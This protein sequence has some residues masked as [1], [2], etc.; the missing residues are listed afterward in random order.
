[1]AAI[2]LLF[3]MIAATA[4]TTVPAIQAAIIM[5]TS[6]PNVSSAIETATRANSRLFTLFVLA[7]LAFGLVTA[8]LT[9]RVRQS[10]TDLQ[11]AIRN[12]AYA[13]IEEA[14]AEGEK[15]YQAAKKLENDNLILRGDLNGAMGQVA[16][17][18]REAAAQ[19]ERAAMAEHAL[20]ELQE[21]MAYRGVSDDQ[22]QTLKTELQSLK[23]E[24]I[25][26]Y[27][28]DIKPEINGYARRI[29]GVLNEAEL[30]ATF[31]SALL[32]TSHIGFLFISGE[33][34]LNAAGVIYT[35]FV[36]ADLA[37]GRMQLQKISDANVLQLIVGPKE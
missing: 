22:V 31:Q 15:A 6:Q 20:L 23:G 3:D 14:K 19:Q 24:N 28:S 37:A 18:Q 26:V 35:A 25:T 1:M 12:D 30:N 10:D 27:T 36:K 13:R 4:N 9:W 7:L 2:L 21:R 33:A 34:R 32:P 17:L 16:E 5:Q 8:Y 11:D 29:T